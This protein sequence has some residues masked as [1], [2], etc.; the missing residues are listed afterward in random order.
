MKK[1][2]VAKWD[3]YQGEE[4]ARAE[5]RRQ[6]GEGYVYPWCRWHGKV[7]NHRLLS[8]PA[9]RNIWPY[10]LV[11]ARE[12]EGV[13]DYDVEWLMHRLCMRKAEVVDGVEALIEYGL[14]ETIGTESETD[15]NAIGTE[16]ERD[17][18]RGEESRGDEITTYSCADAHTFDDF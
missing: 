14:I 16:S 8:K 11:I 6:R 17:R 7:L 5:K 12:H 10:L 4:K 18:T 13:L 15:R 3:M 1:L 9:A 2:K